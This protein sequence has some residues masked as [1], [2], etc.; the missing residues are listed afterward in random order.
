MEKLWRSIA[1]MNYTKTVS[2]QNLVNNIHKKITKNFVMNV[3]IQDTNEASK[4]A[5][6]A[7]W[8]PL[9]SDGIQ[10]QARNER[11]IQSYTNLMEN[12]NSLLKRDTL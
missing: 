6:A 1:I 10:Q 7:L 2:T 12:L 9:K 5:G 11:N 3:L 8:L 4:H